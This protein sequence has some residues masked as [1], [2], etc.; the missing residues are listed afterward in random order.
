LSRPG[1]KFPRTEVRTFR[2]KESVHG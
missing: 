1:R 2:S